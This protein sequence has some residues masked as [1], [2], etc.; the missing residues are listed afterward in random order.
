MLNISVVNIV[1]T[2]LNL[3]ILYFVFKKFLFA[4]VDK[5]LMQRKEE[6][7]E[8]TRA[9]DIATQKALD[10]KKEYEE[11]IARKERELGERR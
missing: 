7:D 3:L 1:C 11:K 10:T 6:V 8:A 2:I 9:A 4:R 5:V